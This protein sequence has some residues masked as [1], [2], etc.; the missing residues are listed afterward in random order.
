MKPD[1]QLLVDQDYLLSRDGCTSSSYLSA[2]SPAESNLGSSAGKCLPAAKVSDTPWLGGNPLVLPSEKTALSPSA[3]TTSHRIR[4]QASLLW[5]G[6][7]PLLLLALFAASNAEEALCG[8]RRITGDL[9]AHE[10]R[11]KRKDRG[12]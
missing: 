5:L 11:P 1:G 12:T 6:D 3:G 2:Q 8:H 10:D 9:G 7:C 4:V